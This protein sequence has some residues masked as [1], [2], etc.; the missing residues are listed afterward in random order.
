MKAER[1]GSPHRS[2]RAWSLDWYEEGATPWGEGEAEEGEEKRAK[3]GARVLCVNCAGAAAGS[4]CV[5]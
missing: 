2:Q 1:R 4:L 3:N 5:A